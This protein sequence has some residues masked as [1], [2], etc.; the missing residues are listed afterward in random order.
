[1][2]RPLIFLMCLDL[3]IHICV[4]MLPCGKQYFGKLF[5]R[6]TYFS[7]RSDPYS[8]DMS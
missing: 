4:C 8:F 2:F 3:E 7:Q 5:E 1:M 6:H